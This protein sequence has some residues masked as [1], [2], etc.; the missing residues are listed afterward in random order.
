MVGG[1]EGVG[2]LVA[3]AVGVSVAASVGIAVGS[4]VGIAVGSSVGAA[5][6]SSVGAAVGSPIGA[7]VGST[8]GSTAGSSVG[9]AVASTVGAAAGSSVGVTVASVDAPTIGTAMAML[10]ARIRAKSSPAMRSADRAVGPGRKVFI[11][12]P[13]LWTSAYDAAIAAARIAPSCGRQAYSAHPDR[14][15][16]THGHAAIVAR[17]AKVRVSRFGADGDM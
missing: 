10:K 3:V 11:E 16:G 7:A 1:P 6:S 14:L 15:N 17:T 12:F 9:A 5:A 4:S 13:L 2:V 8:A